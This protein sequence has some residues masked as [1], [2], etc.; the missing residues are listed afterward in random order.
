[1]E[2]DMVLVYGTALP[3]PAA[4]GMFAAA[5]LPI[6]VTPG[7]SF[8]LATTQALAGNNRGVRT[9]VIGTCMGIGTHAGLAAAGLSAIVMRS[10]YAYELI[11]VLGALYLIA[12][13]L[14]T[15]LRPRKS[16]ASTVPAEPGPVSLRTA[17]LANVLNPKAA[18]VYLTLAPQFLPRELFSLPGLLALA[19]VHAALTAGW[20]LTCTSVLRLATTRGRGPAM[21]NAVTTLGGAALIAL[22]I[23]T[24]ATP[25][26]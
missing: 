9:V 25:R 19:T 4:L 13:G 16:S 8:T 15:L 6:I 2:P 20:L 17:W 3:P 5:M 22:G 24:L 1:M 11:R 7:A 21:T 10:S 26:A 14:I 23:R 12:L 18:A